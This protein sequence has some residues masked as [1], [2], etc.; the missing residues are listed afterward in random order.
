[1]VPM[2]PEIPKM[3]TTKCR[4]LQIFNP[5]VKTVPMVSQTPKRK[6]AASAIEQLSRFGQKG[7]KQLSTAAR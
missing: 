5:I 6:I 4:D 2:I 1:M 3:V 7:P